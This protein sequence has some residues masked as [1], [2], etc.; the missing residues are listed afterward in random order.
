[1]RKTA[2]ILSIFGYN[3]ADFYTG[4]GPL[5][6]GSV[7]IDTAPTDGNFIDYKLEHS[8]GEDCGDW[9]RNREL[10]QE[11]KD[12]YRPIFEQIFPNIDMNKVRL[13]EYCWYNCSEAPD[14][15]DD[16]N[17]KDGFYKPI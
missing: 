15:Y 12:K 10:Y 3:P 4:R 7:G 17:E 6:A 5:E 16:V 11:E 13:V 14:Y 8:Y 2:N 1:M 9:G